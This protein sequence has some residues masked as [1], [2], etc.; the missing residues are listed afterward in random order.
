MKFIARI[1][2]FLFIASLSSDGDECTVTS[3][4]SIYLKRTHSKEIKDFV[5][6]ADI[7]FKFC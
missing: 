7:E 2:L 5:Y 1:F 3:S 4:D 6:Y